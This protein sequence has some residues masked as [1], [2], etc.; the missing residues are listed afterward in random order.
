MRTPPATTVQVATPLRLWVAYTDFEGAAARTRRSSEFLDQQTIR[1]GEW[2][3]SEDL[4]RPVSPDPHVCVHRPRACRRR[5]KPLRGSRRSRLLSE[6]H[7]G[8]YNARGETVSRV[9]R[10]H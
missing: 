2:V 6:V 7:G 5:P 9:P 8:A 1:S 4:G 10:F 3:R